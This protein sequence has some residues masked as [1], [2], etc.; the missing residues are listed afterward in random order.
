LTSGETVDSS[1]GE[2]ADRQL[3]REVAASLATPPRRLPGKLLYDER[4][5][6]LFDRLTEQP[7][8]YMTRTELDLVSKYA[9][10]IA[11]QVPVT[12]LIDLGSGFVTKTKIILAAL[13]RR[14]GNI[15]YLPVDVSVD[16]LQ[17]A[18]K[19][20]GTH[21]N[22]EIEP[23]VADFETDMSFLRRSAPTLITVF[24]NTVGNLEADRRRSFLRNV[25]EVLEPG[26]YVLLSVDLVKDPAVLVRAHNDVA[27][28]AAEF[29]RHALHVINASMHA[30]FDPDKFDYS[31]RWN[32]A[33]SRVEMF[34]QPIV[35]HQVSIRDLP[36]EVTFAAG[37]EILAGFSVKFDEAALEAEC[38]AAGFMPYKWWVD[39]LKRIGVLVAKC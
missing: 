20:I 4:G 39:P 37:E 14:Y 8:Y 34:L 38:A 35:T 32:P 7:E 18:N 25:R 23:V 21:P 15:H 22:I 5:C 3:R 17:L 31:A 36:L 10:E 1:L 28:A 6:A 33:M 19:I 27:Q 26:G 30:D 29:H 12:R 11:D 9:T 13:A 2:P 24:G 16:A